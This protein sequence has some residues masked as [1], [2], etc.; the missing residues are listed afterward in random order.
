MTLTEAFPVKTHRRKS[1]FSSGGKIQIKCRLYDQRLQDTQRSKKI[2]QPA[3][4]EKTVA[5]MIK[6][7]T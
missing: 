1:M 5:Q 3:K 6:C 2:S 7:Q 4:A